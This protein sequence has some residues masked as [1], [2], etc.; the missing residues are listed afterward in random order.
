MLF[1]H[2]STGMQNLALLG[3]NW[4]KINKTPKK[5]KNLPTN[6][7]FFGEQITI[8]PVRILEMYRSYWCR[9]QEKI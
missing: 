8:W 4:S 5:I 7:S 9:P 6:M 3:K 1:N 2:G